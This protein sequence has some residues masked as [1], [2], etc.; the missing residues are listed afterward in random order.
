MSKNIT[1]GIYAGL[2]GGSVFGVMMAME[3][4]F[5]MIAGMIGMNHGLVGFVLHLLFS[6]IIGGLFGLILNSIVTGPGTGI[7]VGAIYGVI[8]WVLGPLLI[9]PGVMGMPLFQ[10]EAMMGSLFGHVMF[11][12][13]MGT[14]YLLLHNLPGK[15]ES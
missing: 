12:I 6:A 4:M 10:I 1:N 15:S 9:M 8:W 7:L 11:G 2:F 13:T 14:I 3:G 5:P